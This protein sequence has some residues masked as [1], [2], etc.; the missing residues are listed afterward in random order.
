MAPVASV[1]RTTPARQTFSYTSVWEAIRA[2]G[3]GDVV[4]L[5]DGTYDE[6]CLATSMPLANNTDHLTILGRGHPLIVVHV[7]DSP[8]INECAL[9]LAGNRHL[10]VSNITVLALCESDNN[11][12]AYNAVFNATT[13]LLVEDCVFQSEVYGSSNTFKTFI[14][15]EGASNVV[16]RRSVIITADMTGRNDIYHT[17]SHDAAVPLFERVQFL[18]T[19]GARHNVGGCWAS[20]V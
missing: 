8:S 6:A 14:T 18:G 17:A 3:S 9:N 15:T 2:A 7:T 13:D 5:G 20:C 4:S 11:W 16:V 12:R 1:L 10:H 19:P